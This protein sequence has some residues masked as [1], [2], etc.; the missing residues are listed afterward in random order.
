MPKIHTN[1]PPWESR[2][3]VIRISQA[4][5][6]ALLFAAQ[7]STSHGLDRHK[8]SYCQEERRLYAGYQNPAQPPWYVSAHL[9]F[10]PLT[11]S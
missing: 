2:P 3:E 6:P 7:G 10:L 9:A 4:L 8:G 11:S 5:Q 1:S